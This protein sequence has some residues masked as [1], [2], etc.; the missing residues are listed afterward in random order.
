[1][2][3]KQKNNGDVNV[4]EHKDRS[5][6]VP[7]R[8]K[9]KT[10]LSIY[11]RNDLTEKQKGILELILDKKT[12]IVFISGCAGTSKTY[13]AVYAGLMALN[14]KTQSDILY[15]RSAIESASK[16]LGYLPGDKDLKTEVY[17]AP[18]KDKLDELLPRTEMEELMKDG[19]IKGEMVNYIRG[20]SWNAKYVIAEESQN[21]SK[22]E[23]LTIMTRLGKHS[24]L[25]IIGDPGQVDMKEKSAFMPFFDLFNTEESKDYGIYCVS[26]TRAD[27]VR[28]KILGYILD[29]IEGT[30]TPPTV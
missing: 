25:I 7:Q 9:I 18:L 17:L 4:E 15:L 22:N 30:Y 29:K 8:D 24:K 2:A 13:L 11:H 14:N 6:K 3:K 19:R 5:Q 27:I 1:M 26:F 28:S 23:I 12:N 10:S 20:S 21:Y 16:S